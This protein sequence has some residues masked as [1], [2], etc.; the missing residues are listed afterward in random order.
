MDDCRTRHNFVMGMYCFQVAKPLGYPEK[1]KGFTKP[2]NWAAGCHGKTYSNLPSN[3]VEMGFELAML[4]LRLLLP[5]L[6]ALQPMLILGMKI[7]PLLD[8]ISNKEQYCPAKTEQGGFWLKFSL[9]AHA[10]F[11]IMRRLNFN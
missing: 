10:T 7:M 3:C 9:K 2:I 6:S 11:V 5:R 8:K 1:Y 4:M